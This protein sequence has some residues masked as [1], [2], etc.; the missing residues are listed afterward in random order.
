MRRLCR[1]AVAVGVVVGV[2][3]FGAP[4][5]LAHEQ[6]QVGAYQF[7]V[8]WGQ[9]PTYIGEQNKVQLFIHDTHGNPVDGI[10]TPPTLHVEVIFGS[11]TSPP[12]DLEPSFDPDTGLG[13]HGEFDAAIIPTAVGDFTF[14]FFGSIHGQ[15]VDERFTSGP[16]TFNPVQ[17]PTGIEF[18]AKVPTLP[19]LAALAGRLGPRVDHAVAQ[20]TSTT[21]KADSAHTLGLVGV[22]M[23]ATG[24][25]LGGAALIMGRRR[26][27]RSKASSSQMARSAP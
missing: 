13:T 8:G 2:C 24:L 7:T 6:R 22:I 25:A 5:A 18:P 3:L 23:G 16:T 10:E 17:D 9:E 1:A 11:L 19:D 15:K 27:G 14:H 12:L 21:S 4:A 26:R 20:A